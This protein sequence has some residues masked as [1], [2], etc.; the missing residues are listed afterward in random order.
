MNCHAF[1]SKLIGPSFYEITRRYSLAEKVEDTLVNHLLNGSTGRWGPAKMPSNSNLNKAQAKNIIEWLFKNAADPTVNYLAGTEG[2]FRLNSP[3]D[4][5]KNVI[6][7]ASYTDHG[8]KDQ[9]FQN[10][11]GED[12]IILHGK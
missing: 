7:I 11:K 10:M 3:A 8:V 5:L 4:S 1:K 12:M 6:L 2:S 9:P